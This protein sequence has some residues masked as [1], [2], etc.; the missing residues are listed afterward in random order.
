MEKLLF[1]GDATGDRSFLG[2]VSLMYVISRSLYSI[3]YLAYLINKNAKASA[4]YAEA[5]I[6]LFYWIWS[7]QRIKQ[8]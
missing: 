3:S 4:F 5:K 2:L 6:K 7:L 8:I 1:N